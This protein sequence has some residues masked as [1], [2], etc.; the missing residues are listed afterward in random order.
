MIELLHMVIWRIGCNLAHLLKMFGGV[1]LDAG[2]KVGDSVA[3]NHY[4]KTSK[5]KSVK[6]SL[7]L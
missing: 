7:E 4:H 2:W 3:K 6:E 1:L 5:G